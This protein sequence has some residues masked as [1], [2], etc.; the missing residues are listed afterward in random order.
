MSDKKR[1]LHLF[2][3]LVSFDSPSFGE[4]DICDFIKKQLADT[5]LSVDEDN[6]AAI[7]GGTCGNLY[8]FAD[9]SLSLPPLLFCAHMDTVEPSH[10]KCA[11]ADKNG[12]ITSAGATV[13]GADDCAGIA[14]ILE[15][16]AS[17]R[18]AKAPHRPLEFLFTY[19]EE[20]YC[21]GIRQFDFSRLRSKEAYVLD[22]TGPVGGA[23][24]QAPAIISFKAA[25]SGRA[26]H[27][28]FDPENGINAVKAAAE[29]ISRTGC[30]RTNGMTVNIGTVSGGT[31]D[32]IVPD[33]CLLT[34]EIRS[35]SDTEAKEK[36]ESIFAVFR[37]AAEKFGAS[38]ETWSTVHFPAYSTDVSSPVVQRFKSACAALN[39][40][41][42]LCSTFG[43]SDNNHLAAHGISGIV[44]APGMNKCHSCDEFTTEDELVRA[45]DI[46]YALM[47]S[48]E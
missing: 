2:E 13:L 26:A 6:S 3:Q 33:K 1:L 23:A 8:A 38:V 27:A 39:I 29:A 43:G 30:G 41:V 7:T 37:N 48:Q 25:F 10:G 9:G 31:A 19:A 21:K 47:T 36:L 44:A 40:P 35:Y 32:N 14:E 24:Y 11:S 17:V 18:E 4:R 5:G 42:S 15:A 12:V 20:P 22:L 28:G 45:A 46:V 34:G 16:W